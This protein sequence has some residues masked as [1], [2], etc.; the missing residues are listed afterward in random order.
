MERRKILVVRKAA[1][2]QG[3][4][5]LSKAEDSNI[6]LAAVEAL[7]RETA[8]ISHGTATLTVHVKDGKWN[9]FTTSRERSFVLGKPRSGGNNGY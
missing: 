8:G 3:G 4:T 9:R 5:T 6:L 2:S 7:E 1:T